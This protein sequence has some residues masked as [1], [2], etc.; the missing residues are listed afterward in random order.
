MAGVGPGVWTVLTAKG[1]G[2]GEYD[3]CITGSF[4]A[5]FPPI[6]PENNTRRRINNI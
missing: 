6:H 4:K 1:V 3:G 2:V 5:L